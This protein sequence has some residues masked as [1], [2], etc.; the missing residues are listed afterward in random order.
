M[1]FNAILKNKLFVSL[2][3]ELEELESDRIFCRHGIDH[4][5]DVARA[6]YIISLESGADIGKDIIYATALLHDIG[7]V[8]QYKNGTPHDIAGVAAAKKILMQTGF[9]EE[10]IQ[11]ITA[12]IGMHRTENGANTLSG[13]IYRADKLTRKCFCC[14]A[15]AECNWSDNK[16]NQEMRY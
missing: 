11:A 10:E 16:K 7:R 14:K 2:I 6:A 3:N 1:K 4:L 5:F 8:E 12:A 9:N 15:A 13:I